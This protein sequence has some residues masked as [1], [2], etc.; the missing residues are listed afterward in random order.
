[1][2]NPQALHI[3]FHVVASFKHSRGLEHRERRGGKNDKRGTSDVRTHARRNLFEAPNCASRTPPLFR[4]LLTEILPDT[5]HDILDSYRLLCRLQPITAVP[6]PSLSTAPSCGADPRPRL[7]CSLA[8]PSTEA[9]ASVIAR[10]AS[11][12]SAKRTTAGRPKADSP[13]RHNASTSFPLPKC[14][15]QG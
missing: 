2:C 10:A 11:L 14:T 1:M 13:T 8:P 6:L 4:E 7:F 12:G 3:C 9:T 5:C 15:C